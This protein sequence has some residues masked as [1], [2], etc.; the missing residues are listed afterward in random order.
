MKWSYLL[1]LFAFT[2]PL[3]SLAQNLDEDQLQTLINREIISIELSSWDQPTFKVPMKGV[4]NIVQRTYKAELGENEELVMSGIKEMKEFRFDESGYQIWELDS[5][6]YTTERTFAYDDRG[7]CI[8]VSRTRFDKT[9]Q[10]LFS[11]SDEG[12]LKEVTWGDDGEHDIKKII[13]DFFDLLLI[14]N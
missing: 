11:Y 3:P 1:L 4:Q 12:Q 5:A 14:M 10:R 9:V 6:R 7:H 13:F 8:S 2:Y